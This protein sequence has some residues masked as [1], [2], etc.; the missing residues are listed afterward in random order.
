VFTTDARDEIIEFG[1]GDGSIIINHIGIDSDAA[2]RQ[3]LDE[4]IRRLEAF[5]ISSTVV[6]SSP[7]G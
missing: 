5:G 6:F 3:F 1:V 7:C 2:A 4:F